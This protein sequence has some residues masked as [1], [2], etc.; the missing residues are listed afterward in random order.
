M[1]DQAGTDRSRWTALYVLCVGELMI[2]L[3]A[4]IVNVALPSIRQDLDFSQS[5]LAWIV[6]AYLIAFGGL[7]LLAGRLG[8]LIGKR[9]IFLTG[10]TVFTV[11]SLLC[12]VAQNQLMLIVSRFAQGV[13][14]ALTSAVILGM[15]VTLFPEPREQAKAIGVYGFI[16]ASGGSIGLLAGGSLT[17]AMNWHWVFLINLPVGVATAALAV[18]HVADPEGIGRGQRADV[19][20]A[21]LL[22]AGL[23]LGVYTIL[24]VGTWGWLSARTLGLGA[25]AIA[26]VTGFLVRQRLIA[27]PLMPLRLFRSRHVSGANIIELLLVAGMF[28]VFFFGALYLQQVLEFDPF[29][30]GLGFLPAALTMGVTALRLSG[31]FSLRFGLRTTLVTS[32]GLITLCLLLYAR[33][34]ADGS[35]AVDVLPAMILFGLGGGLGFPSLMA[36]A[37]SDA[38]ESDAG[39]TSGLLA[40]SYQV[41]GAVG[42]AV[43]TSIAT[44]RTSGRTAAGESADAALN[45][46]YH[47]AHLVAAAL[48]VLAIPVTLAVLRK[49]PQQDDAAA[50]G[51]AE[52]NRT[53]AEAD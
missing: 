2:L 45:S 48:V 36:M 38:T 27:N 35:Y 30:V 22:T 41:G 47:L 39:L 49:T 10:L 4:T 16:T 17:S 11:A 3:D 5:D 7:L 26:L 8:D 19:L 21:A 33:T 32:L 1:T 24:E 34:P 13:G 43:L 37:M 6:N 50:E 44:G 18:R 14:G 52:T 28:G 46:G 20:G 31:P 53:Y 25:A 23:M 29:Q 15:I 9:R 51:A 40:T 42:L 12:A